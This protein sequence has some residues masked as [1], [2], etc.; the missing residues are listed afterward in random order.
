MGCHCFCSY[1]HL[2]AVTKDCKYIDS[3]EFL[4]LLGAY[5]T[6]PKAPRG[7]S[8]D[9]TASW[10]LDIIHLDIAFGDCASVGGFKYAL[11]FMD[12]APQCNW[13]FGLK[14]LQYDEIL[15]AFLAFWSEAGG[16][17]TQFQC[18]WDENLDGNNV[19]SFLHLNHS[20]ISASPEGWQSS[21]G[22]VE[23]H[24]KIIV[25]MSWAY[26]TKKQMPCSF[27]YYAVKH[28]AHMMNMIPGKYVV[29]SRPP[30]CSSIVCT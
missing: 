25:H 21:N 12:Q 29:C 18:N 23:S 24:W 20:S 11:I 9:H 1:K 30:L 4:V 17:A 8:I 3:S 10:Y 26:L 7:K 2:I 27:R 13:C 14:S 22:L 5:M 15:A 16:L 6:I 28:S 19:Q